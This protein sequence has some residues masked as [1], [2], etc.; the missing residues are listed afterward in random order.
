[1]AWSPRACLPITIPWASRPGERAALR[2]PLP[3]P[4]DRTL[5]LVERR[6]P[7]QAQRAEKV[8]RPVT[9][10]RVGPPLSGYV[11]AFLADD[12]CQY[13]SRTEASDLIVWSVQ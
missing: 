8:C 5:A 12:V 3:P 10:L 1:M 2:V 9:S 4:L 13:D 7:V 11:P 6:G